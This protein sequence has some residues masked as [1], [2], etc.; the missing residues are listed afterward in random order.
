MIRNTCFAAVFLSIVFPNLPIVGLGPGAIFVLVLVVSY[1]GRSQGRSQR[2][3]APRGVRRLAMAALA[4]TLIV[5][6]SFVLNTGINPVDLR[7]AASLLGIVLVISAL[8]WGGDFTSSRQYSGY[9]SGI[10][11]GG[12][13]VALAWVVRVVTSGNFFVLRQEDA[14]RSAGFLFSNPNVT[15]RLALIALTGCL[16]IAEVESH[17]RG[18]AHLVAGALGLVVLSTI[19]RANLVALLVLGAS[20]MLL[21]RR[22]GRSKRTT[23]TVVCVSVILYFV[24]SEVFG[25][26]AEIQEVS[27]S[28]DSNLR[29]QSYAAAL[30]VIGQNLWLGVGKSG[31][32]DAMFRA[33]S[34][35][36]FGTQSKT[37]VTHS[38]FLK[39]A[40]YAG[41]PA[42]IVL[43][44][45]L[46][47]SLGTFWILR[48]KSSRDSVSSAAA[49]IGVAYCLALVPMNVGADGFGLAITWFMLGFLFVEA[50]GGGIASR[51]ARERSFER[52]P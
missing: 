50:G 37:I 25:R 10:L 7:Y 51:V 48:K 15:A 5:T 45:V 12:A 35:S 49:S 4:Y 28:L 23:V 32:I 18:H 1:I 34:V 6:V 52:Q 39:A 30:D 2:D 29:G 36:Y 13:V 38:G 16:Y 40:V 14:V 46:L 19:S 17:R 42:A 22:Q 3:P 31:E 8:H 43:C 47:A 41:V 26:L 24:G 9:R 44:L 20:W 11:A 27:I 33:G 21:L